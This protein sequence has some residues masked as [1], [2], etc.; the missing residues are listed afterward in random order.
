[1]NDSSTLKKSKF[2]TKELVLTAMFAAVMAV[3]S[4][5]AIPIGS[6][7]ITLQTFAVFCALGLLGGRNGTFAI[8]VYILL[9]AIGL[10]V[11]TNFKGGIGALTGPTGGYILGFILM[12]LLYWAGTKLFGHK[13]PVSIALMAVGLAVCYLFG[14]IWFV[15]GYSNGETKMTFMGALDVC[16]FPYL[17]F[18][19]IKLVLATVICSRIKKYISI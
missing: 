5:I 18:D 8:A 11:F 15:C 17:P 10:P 7:P 1:M 14:T 6:I 19:I 12:A 2:S 3:C 9:G 16:V 4:W 13:L